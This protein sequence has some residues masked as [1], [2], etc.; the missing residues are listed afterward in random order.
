M[1]L[2]QK[3]Y[4]TISRSSGGNDNQT[5]IRMSIVRGACQIIAAITL[6]AISGVDA[7]AAN[8]W[9]F[10]SGSGG[11][12][13]YDKDT[14]NRTLPHVFV[15]R[16]DVLFN[17]LP[18]GAQYNEMQ[19]RFDIDCSKGTEQLLAQRT[20]LDGHLLSTSTGEGSVEPIEPDSII[21]WLEKEVCR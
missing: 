7:S 5:G 18:P 3:L 13:A 19:T 16:R 4:V 15:W 9:I 8:W 21:Q 14:V 11:T 10:A 2:Q 6:L 1:A 20:F 12:N 17:P